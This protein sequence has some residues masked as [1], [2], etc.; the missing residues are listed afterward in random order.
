MINIIKNNFGKEYK[1]ISNIMR[2][3]KVQTVVSDKEH[4]SK[5]EN[6][7]GNDTSIII[8]S[9]YINDSLTSFCHDKTKNTV[10]LEK[11]MSNTI[12]RK[13]TYKNI[14][15]KILEF[16]KIIGSHKNSADFI[17][18]LEN[19]FFISGGTDNK[20]VVYSPQYEFIS[21]RKFPDSIY[22]ISETCETKMKKDEINLIATSNERT[23]LINLDYKR[24]KLYIYLEIKGCSLCVEFKDDNYIICSN[25]QV[26]HL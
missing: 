5:V 12:G 9:V 1:D 18:E 7:L 26:Y 3:D 25:N 6:H 20:L 15:F 8:E 2:A 11:G 21:Q 17:V 19:N 13:N 16:I 24:N 23:Y 22:N 4:D 10:S 14:D